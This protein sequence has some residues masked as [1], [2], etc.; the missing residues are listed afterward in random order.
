MA[1]IFF[2]WSSYLDFKKDVDPDVHVKV[3]NFAMKANAETF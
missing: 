1:K 3:F 2:E